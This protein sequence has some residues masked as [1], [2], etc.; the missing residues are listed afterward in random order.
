MIL[1]CIILCREPQSIQT[2]LVHMHQPFAGY[3]YACMFAYLNRLSYLCCQIHKSACATAANWMNTNNCENDR[4]YL[5]YIQQQAWCQCGCSN[6]WVR[7]NDLVIYKRA[8]PMLHCCTW[9]KPPCRQMDQW[10]NGERKM[11]SSSILNSTKTTSEV[12]LFTQ[13]VVIHN[14]NDV[15]A[16]QLMMR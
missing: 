7:L 15:Y 3:S 14:N 2:L 9:N 11:I 10:V 8:A 1:C 16:F 13:I 12:Y 6:T 4:A 5:H